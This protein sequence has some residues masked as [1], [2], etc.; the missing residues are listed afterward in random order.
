[1]QTS[2]WKSCKVFNFLVSY[3]LSIVALFWGWSRKLVQICRT[4]GMLMLKCEGGGNIPK[5]KHFQKIFVIGDSSFCSGIR[6]LF[7]HN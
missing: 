2:E 5:T 6:L 4:S 3:V 7:W 1:M